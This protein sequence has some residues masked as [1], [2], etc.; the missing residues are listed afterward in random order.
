MAWILRYVVLAQITPR[1]HHIE[2][3]WWFI[4]SV[5]VYH[6]LNWPI[7]STLGFQLWQEW[8]Q[9]DQEIEVYQRP[10]GG[11]WVWRSPLGRWI[12]RGHLPSTPIKYKSPTTWYKF[13]PER[14]PVGKK[15]AILWRH[16]ITSPSFKSLVSTLS[17]L[18]VFG[19]PRSL[20]RGGPCPS[21]AR[22]LF[23]CSHSEKVSPT[24]FLFPPL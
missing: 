3:S 7:L 1:L 13:E 12:S 18:T 11:L 5:A 17:Q 24:F 15:T 8:R 14:R 22:A 6:N 9:Q 23:T 4:V 20:L 10:Q 16:Q 2:A 19:W 21:Q